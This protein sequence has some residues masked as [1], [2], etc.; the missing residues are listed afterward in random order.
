MA[1]RDKEFLGLDVVSL[2]DASVLGEVDGLLVDETRSAVVGLVLDLGIY[3][4]K[5]LAY[6]DVVTVGEDAVMVT[7]SA[8]VRP[9]SENTILREIAERDVQITD[10]LVMNDQGNVIGVAGDY[11]LDPNDGTIKGLEVVT[12]IDVE[13]LCGE[14]SVVPLGQARI[15]QDLVMVQSGY[16]Q[17][18]VPSGD[19]L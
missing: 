8:T 6:E 11:F 14:V 4:A 17:H 9:V 1:R 5:V 7:S 15:G 12:D 3:E 2:E 10:A 18:T 13:A 19:D 16:E